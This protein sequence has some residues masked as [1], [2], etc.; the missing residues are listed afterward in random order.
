MF[1][2]ETF[3]WE[4][5]WREKFWREKFW[6]ENNHPRPDPFGLRYFVLKTYN[7]TVPS[8]FTIL[9]INYSICPVVVV[10]C[11]GIKW[12][13]VNTINWLSKLIHWHLDGCQTIQE[14]DNLFRNELGPIEWK[15]FCLRNFTIWQNNLKCFS[16]SGLV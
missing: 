2:Q 6:R 12:R 9:W 13:V 15:V 14:E 10:G 1:G 8:K 16:L 5:F 11:Q 4:K 3:C 7:F